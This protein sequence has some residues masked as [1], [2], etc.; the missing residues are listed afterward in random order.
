MDVLDDFGVLVAWEDADRDKGNGERDCG[1]MSARPSIV[2]S[3]GE[4]KMSPLLWAAFF[5]IE[6][7]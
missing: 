2:S 1:S 3:Q 7:A 5:K 4:K 6:A